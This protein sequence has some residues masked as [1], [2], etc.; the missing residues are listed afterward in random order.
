MYDLS[1]TLPL[2]PL[3]SL[4]PGNALLVSRHTRAAGDR[5]VTE[6]LAD[7]LRQDEG[8]IAVS[9]DDDGPDRLADLGAATGAF[10][11]SAVGV[12]DCGADPERTE[13]H[14]QN[15][16]FHYSVPDATDLTGIGIGITKCFDRLRSSGTSEAR[17]G[18]TSLSTI[19]TETDRKIT[20]KL[21]PAPT[22]RL[23]S[24]GF[25]GLFTIH[26]TGHDEQTRQVIRQ[27]FD[28][29]VELRGD[30]D[31]R[32]ARVRGLGDAETDWQSL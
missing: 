17:L 32:E 9:T 23:T 3:L 20:F 21:C 14:L 24:A 15:E 22:S 12:I 1:P 4:C 7:G 26:A 28:G 19:L 29:E 10:D 6:L 8:A 13:Q 16:A 25:L 27:A 31:S 30:D 5:I 2:D 11:G 18:L